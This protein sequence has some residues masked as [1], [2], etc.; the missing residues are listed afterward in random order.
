MDGQAEF[1]STTGLA[2][3]LIGL[4]L[5]ITIVLHIWILVKIYKNAALLV[6]VIRRHIEAERA[7][8]DIQ[9]RDRIR[10]AKMIRRRVTEDEWIQFL[11]ELGEDPTKPKEK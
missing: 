2:F 4:A 10:I 3:G 8:R 1:V 7:R 9:E 5:L 11:S 6:R